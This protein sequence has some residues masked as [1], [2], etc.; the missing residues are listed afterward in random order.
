MPLGA[1]VCVAQLLFNF[2]LDM[3][4]SSGAPFWSGPKR[5]PTPLT[6]DSSNPLHVEFIVAAA[7][8][9]A[10]NYGLKGSSDR[11]FIR[12]V[13]ESA[14]VPEFVPRSGVKIES[15][16]NKEKQQ[17]PGAELH[18]GSIRDDRWAPDGRVGCDGV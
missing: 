2:P 9:R 16:P 12:R 4:T 8:L 14:M 11:D 7:N 13:A 5:P 17:Q 6:F 10:F 18:W 1:R 3:T 15:D